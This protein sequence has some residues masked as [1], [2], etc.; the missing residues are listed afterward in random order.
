[1]SILASILGGGFTGL[2]GTFLSGIVQYFTMK[3]KNKHEIA[4]LDA[5]SKN[6]IA[7]V[8]ANI[9]RDKVQTAGAVEIAETE[10]FS[11]SLESMS[12]PLFMESYMKGLMSGGQ[13]GQACGVILSFLFG[14]VDFIT[15][16]AR[17]A[18][19]Y[20]LMGCT[21]WLTVIVYEVLEK[22]SGPVID[23]VWAKALFGDIVYAIIYMTTSCVMWWFGD[24]RVGK[25]IEKR[26]S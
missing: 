15:R 11:K 25:A 7:E 3:E 5:E 19:T 10:A 24:R 1:M 26:F 17:P 23:A 20:Y 8:S 22:A 2:F 18:L 9:E 21:T 6:M 4:L 12:K 16:L 14:M 13:F